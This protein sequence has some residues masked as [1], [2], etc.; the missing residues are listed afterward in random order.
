MAPTA[1]TPPRSHAY[2]SGSPSGSD[3]VE[4]SKF[5]GTPTIPVYG[6]PGFAV[7]HRFMWGRTVIVKLL[8]SVR[9]PSLA[10]TVAAYVPSSER[11]GAR[12]MLPVPVPGPGLVVVTLMK[13][14][15]DTLEKAMGAPAGFDPAMAWSAIGRA[16]RRVIA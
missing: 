15:P 4:P 14:G 7:G 6:P 3:E 12:W 2:V 8:E 9:L 11:P 1:G 13:V 5:T 16:A 10:E